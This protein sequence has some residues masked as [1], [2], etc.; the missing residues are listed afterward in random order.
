MQMATNAE[1]SQYDGAGAVTVNNLG[2]RLKRDVGGTRGRRNGMGKK[3]ISQIGIDQLSRYYWRQYSE[4]AME[5]STKA[6]PLTGIRFHSVHQG[7]SDW[8]IPARQ[9][10]F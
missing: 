2:Q 10:A 5:G 9:N 4:A 1:E 6:A 7:C 8:R 3:L